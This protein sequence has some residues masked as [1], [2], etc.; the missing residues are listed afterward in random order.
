MFY[1]VHVDLIQK[2]NLDKNK[3][4]IWIE[5]RAILWKKRFTWNDVSEYSN[6]IKD[7]Q[8]DPPT[9]RIVQPSFEV[10]EDFSPTILKALI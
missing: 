10:Q 9:L 4:H 5:T 1:A 8:L 2:S 7:E 6:G 3:Y